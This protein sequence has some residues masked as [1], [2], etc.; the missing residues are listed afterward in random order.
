MGRRSLLA[1]L[2]SIQQGFA[3]VDFSLDER[4]RYD[5]VR[6]RISASRSGCGCGAMLGVRI[7]WLGAIDKRQLAH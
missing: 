1:Y 3:E 2:D 6:N 4:F 7:L 5:V